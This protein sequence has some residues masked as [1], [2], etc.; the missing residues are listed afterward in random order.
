MTFFKAVYKWYNRPNKNPIADLLESLLVI[1]PVVFLIKTFIFGLYQVPTCSMETTM[2]VGERYFADK[3][4][5]YFKPPVRRDIISF[6]QPIGYNYSKNP[7]INIFQRYVDWNVINWTKRVIGVPGDHVQGKI[8]DGKPVV[9]VNGKKLDEP[10]LNQ[11][12]IIQLYKEDAH[13][14]HCR[15]TFDPEKSWKDQPFYEITPLEITRAKQMYRQTIFNPNTP[16]VEGDRN[17]D[18]YDIHL[19][20]NQYWVMGDN[21][22]G[23]YDSRMWGPLD[24]KLIHGKILFRIW[25]IDSN[26]SWW[27]V[28]LFKHPIGFWKKVRWSRFFDIMK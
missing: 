28:D 6:N 9:Y 3:L 17:F 27:F 16:V 22:Q 26:Q 8:E 14:K 10:Y 5:V 18:E 2:L 15:R 25:S 11:Y 21:R 7:A 12:P 13:G 4:T 19:K 24:G 20:D 23:S 1:V